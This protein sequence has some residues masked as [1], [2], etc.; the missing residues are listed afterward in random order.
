[1]AKPRNFALIGAAGFI[2]PR[3]LQAIKD[4]QGTLV[5]ALDPHDAVGILD[6]FFPETAFFTE[7]E[8]F[9]RHAEKLRRRSEEERIHYV[10][11]CSPNYLH[12]AHI[13]FGL[14][15]GADVICEKPLVINPW[16][17]D[18]LE[19]LEKE[20]GKR[21]WTLLQLRTHPAIRELREQIFA[22]SRDT[23]HEI[24]LTYVTSR[25]QWYFAS[26]KADEEKSGSVLMNI[27]IHFFD[28]LL[29]IFGPVSKVELHYRDAARAAGYLEFAH[30]R[31]RWFLSVDR[32]D[33][34]GIA[35][36]TNTTIDKPTY[37]LLTVNGKPFEFSEGFTDLHTRVYEETLAG[38][39]FGIADARPSITLVH[40]LRTSTVT[41][42]AAAHHAHGYLAHIRANT[43]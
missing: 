5:A 8:R 23:K 29:W 6:R 37:R 32:S 36:L 2:A 33:L 38:K 13:R 17:L 27:G 31:V 28:M 25:G 15:I 3:H 39:G 10:T 42:P 30:A 20:T 24:E 43:P 41:K 14:R 26:W 11:V 16:N 22:D 12:D 18:G 40:T 21:V 1:M 7:F 4:V 19:Q 34:A 35:A 9:D